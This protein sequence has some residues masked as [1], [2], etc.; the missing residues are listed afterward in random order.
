MRKDLSKRALREALSKY[1]SDAISDNVK[2]VTKE[3]EAK[4]RR[5]KNVKMFSC[6][7]MKSKV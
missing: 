5:A 4:K 6:Y 2:R 1:Y 3:K 7:V